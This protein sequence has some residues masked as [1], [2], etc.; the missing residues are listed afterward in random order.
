VTVMLNG[1]I[2]D[3]ISIA[4][5]HNEKTYDVTPAAGGAPNMLELS[6][7]RTLNPAKQHIGTDARDLGVLV[8]AISF[9]PA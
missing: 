5:E 3:R 7:D 9:G 2:I 6:I 4:A 8:W 1:V